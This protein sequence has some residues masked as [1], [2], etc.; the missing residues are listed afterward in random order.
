MFYRNTHIRIKITGLLIIL[1][2]ILVIIKVFYIQVISYKKLNKL[3]SSLWNRN[4]PIE[5]N[6]GKIYDSTGVVLADNKTTVSLVLVPN[7][8][9]NKD[10]VSKEL[11]NILNISKEKMDKHVNKKS[12]IE[13]QF[14]ICLILLTLHYI[15]H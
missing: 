14:S 10:L 11:A 2:F 8:I 13:S 4:L 1:L 6:R 7:Q 3:A 15:I 5:A 9:K 12:S